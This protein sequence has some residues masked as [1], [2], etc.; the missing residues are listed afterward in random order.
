[1]TDGER[2]AKLTPADEAVVLLVEQEIRIVVESALEIAAKKPCRNINNNWLNR[3][4]SAPLSS[5]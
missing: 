5:G 4:R 1:M 3:L 2:L